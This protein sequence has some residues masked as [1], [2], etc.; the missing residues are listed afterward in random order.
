MKTG[1][2]SGK[3]LTHPEFDLKDPTYVRQL[4]TRAE[5]TKG[6]GVP[7]VAFSKGPVTCVNEQ[8]GYGFFVINRQR[9]PVA[10]TTMRKLA[11]ELT[12]FAEEIE[13]AADPRMLAAEAN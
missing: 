1:T 3:G 11:A 7:P 9:V 10:Y 4:L 13:A 6:V 5:T 12:A 2:E 8:P